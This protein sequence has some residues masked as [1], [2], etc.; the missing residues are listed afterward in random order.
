V[1]IAAIGGVGGSGTRVLAEI[2][3]RVGFAFGPD[4]NDALDN[5]WFTLLF[6]YRV[7][8]R[9]HSL[10]SSGSVAA[11]PGSRSST[12]EGR[13]RA[14]GTSIDSEQI[15]S[16]KTWAWKEPNTHIFVDRI[17]KLE[18]QLRYIHVIRSGVDMA[19]S[20]NRN[21]LELWGPLVL[22]ERFEDSPRGALRFWRWANERILELQ[23]TFS[24]RIFVVRFERLCRS[25]GDTISTMAEF[26]GNPIAPEI[27]DALAATVRPPPSSGSFLGRKD[28]LDRDDLAFAENLSGETGNNETG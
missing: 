18:P 27:R 1:R 13:Q 9:L 5:L 19:F 3:N 25:P 26:L 12:V 22:G 8:A 4:H 16:C 11:G 15:T 23:K 6:K 17:L 10:L 14:Y 7:E 21:Q 24:D 20:G 2:V 28:E